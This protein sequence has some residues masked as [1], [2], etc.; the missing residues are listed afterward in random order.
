[1]NGG[2]NS[3]LGGL[4]SAITLIILNYAT[5]YIAYRNKSLEKLI[6]GTPLVLI[7][8]GMLF[9]DVMEK[10]KISHNELNAALR[11]GGCSSIDEV[12]FAILENNGR[13]SIKQKNVN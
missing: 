8:N 5:G 13:I 11:E 1:M 3:L 10:E 2:D 4:I 9:T 12:H 6:D 7:H